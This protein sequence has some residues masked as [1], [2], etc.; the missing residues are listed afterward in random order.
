MLRRDTLDKVGACTST[1][2]RASVLTFTGVISLIINTRL[3]VLLRY[4]WCRYLQ[5]GNLPLKRPLG[6][7]GGHKRCAVDDPNGVVINIATPGWNEYE[8]EV[9]CPQ[10]TAKAAGSVERACVISVTAT[11]VMSLSFLL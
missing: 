2:R 1:T 4:R 5:S 6:S 11:L 9:N 10:P 7:V 8:E 3:L